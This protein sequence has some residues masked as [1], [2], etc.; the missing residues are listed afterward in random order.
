MR[1]DLSKEVQRLL[2]TQTKKRR[3]SKR[4]MSASTAYLVARALRFY[5]SYSTTSSTIKTILANTRLNRRATSV[6]LALP[7]YWIKAYHDGY[8]ATR[9]RHGIYIFF[10]RKGG[11]TN[12]PRRPADAALEKRRSQVKSFNRILSASQKKTFAKKAKEAG[13]I[14]TKKRRAW[15]GDPFFTKGVRLFYKMAEHDLRPLIGKIF[16]L[17]ISKFEQAFYRGFGLTVKASG[18]GGSIGS[19]RGLEGLFRVDMISFP[20]DGI[21]KARRLT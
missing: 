13:A 18:P 9:K 20:Q 16:E 4:D 10:P 1:R 15:R 17:E 5:A 14:F 7:H 19:L 6:N 3:L 8:R 11:I 12:D 2:A 21:S